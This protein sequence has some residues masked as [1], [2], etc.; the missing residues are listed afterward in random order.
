MPE[1]PRVAILKGAWP[2]PS[3]SP[4]CLKLMTWLRMAGIEYELELLKGPARSK[5]RK[6]PYLIRGD[7]S[8]LDDSSI[9]V[10]TLTR[11]HG[12]TL[13]A[14]RSPHERALM[15][16]VQ[17]T[18]ESH[19]YFV[20]LLHRWRDHWPQTREAYFGGIMPWPVRVVVGP[21][22]RRQALA[23]AHGQGVGRRPPE[24]VHAEAVADLDALAEILGERDFFFGSPGVTDA[25]VYGALENA[26]ACPLPGVVQDTIVSS[27]RW[28][29]YLDRIKTRY[30]A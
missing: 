17:R 9:I 14:D 10:D 7:G 19:L 30:W 16:L 24:Q 4:A 28:M 12:V 20:G 22:I 8:L 2:M 13:D 18:V 5:T 6:A 26:R 25:I 21:I 15:V 11:E 3:E 27:E 29:A 1:T 23:Q